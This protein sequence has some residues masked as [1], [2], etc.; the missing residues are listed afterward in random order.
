MTS[1]SASTLSAPPS[2]PKAPTGIDG[3]DEITGG[4]LPRGR[5]T[6]VCGGPGCG[7]TLLAAEFIVRGATEFGEPGVFM[8]FEETAG[9]LA[10]NVASL[11]FDLPELVEEGKLHIDHVRVERQEIEETGAYDLE[12]LFVRLEYAVRKIGAKRV[13]LD[14]VETLFGGLDDTA[15][16]RSE[17]K[18]LFQWLK[19]RDLTAIVTGERGESTLTRHGLEEYVSDCVIALDHRVSSEVSTRR[20][21][22]VKYRGSAHGTNEYP[23]LLD[24]HG[25][26][27]VPITSARLDH[28]ASEERVSTGIDGLDE[29]MGGEGMFRG[30]SG[31]ISGTA[32]TGKTTA[33]AHFVD[34]ACRRGERALF[35][36]F[37]ESPAQIARNMRSVGLDLAPHVDGGLLRFEAARPTLQGLE[38]HLAKILRVTDEFDPAV[39]VLDP[40]TALLG[41]AVS[42]EVR[43]LVIRL[44][45]SLKSRGIT[46]LVTTLTGMG[47]AS[48]QQT[49]VGISSLVDAWIVLRDTETDARRVRDI[50]VVKARGTAHSNRVRRFLVTSEG[51]EMVPDERERARDRHA[52]TPESPRAGGG[53]VT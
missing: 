13:V 30:S 51:I 46:A 34:A 23:F 12:G 49:G 50:C 35:F 3:L 5:P 17:L 6:L 7:K 9:D 1:S 22:I 8:V 11:G 2:L 37:E 14:T 24:E 39:V 10:A 47:D 20:L 36:A 31:L 19:D 16:L 15:V 43:A 44:V 4:G 27:V 25:V 38:A 21:R 29:M 41:S 33:C 45:D 42:E 40:I 52:N 18:R 32:G 53:E 26:T 48:L 28:G